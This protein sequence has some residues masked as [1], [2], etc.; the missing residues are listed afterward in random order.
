VFILIN[1]IIDAIKLLMPVL[2][3]SLEGFIRINTDSKIYRQY[4]YIVE[5]SFFVRPLE[6]GRKASLWQ[7]QKAQSNSP[8]C[9][10]RAETFVLIGF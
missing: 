3:I 4:P 2:L 9:L 5:N 6:T 10:K 1:I 7:C 8:N